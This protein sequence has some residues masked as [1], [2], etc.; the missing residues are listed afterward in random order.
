MSS[1]K[2]HLC[3]HR[4]GSKKRVNIEWVFYFFVTLYYKA[5]YICK[6]KTLIQPIAKN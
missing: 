6:S 2:C 5:M 4:K 1:L 3:N